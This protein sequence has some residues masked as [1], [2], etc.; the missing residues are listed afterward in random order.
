MSALE[1]IDKFIIEKKFCQAMI[2]KISMLTIQSFFQR[3]A[4]DLNL[5]DAVWLFQKFY[6]F[7]AA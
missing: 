3:I 7:F 6:D 1:Q 2:A 4:A 5:L